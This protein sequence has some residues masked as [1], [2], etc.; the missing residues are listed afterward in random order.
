[1]YTPTL[2]KKKI[3]RM[4]VRKA[5]SIFALLS[6]FIFSVPIGHVQAG[7]LTT[8]RDYLNRSQANVTTAVQHEVFFT[9]TTA[10]TGGAGVNK[11]KLVFPN[12]AT[13]NTKWCRTV[14]T[15]DLTVTGIANPTGATETATILPRT[16]TG[17]CTQTPDTITISGV[18][19]L[20]AATK[21]GVRIAQLS[22]T[23]LGTASAATDNIQVTVKTN[24]G[25]T[26]IDTQII[27]LSVQTSDQVTVSATVNPSLTVV[28]SAT[29]AALGTLDTTHV[30]QASITDTITTNAPNGYNMGV[31]YVTTLTDATSDTI[32]DTAGGTIQVGE[33]EFGVSTSQTSSPLNTISVWNP[34]SC[35]TTTSTTTASALTNAF[36]TFG[37]ASVGTTST[38]VTLCFAASITGTTK[39]GSYTSTATVVTTAKF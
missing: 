33:A 3:H 35:A 26:D 18:N 14:G 16:L 34:T 10:V 37:S 29:T 23:I 36:Q 39:P 15:G 25:T 12:D 38:V 8:P 20:S 2:L 30:N 11:I 28:I 17:A 31:K 21:Y 32:A 7:T 4:V 6:L 5:L 13:N 27:A 24:D 19:N 22:S 9:A 1:M